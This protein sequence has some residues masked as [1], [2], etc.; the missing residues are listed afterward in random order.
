MMMKNWHQ[1]FLRS[2]PNFVPNRTRYSFFIVAG[3]TLN[4][5][6]HHAAESRGAC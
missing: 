5:N 2:L 4:H 1:I 6:K 3:N